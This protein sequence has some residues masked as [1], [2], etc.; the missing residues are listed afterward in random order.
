MLFDSGLLN[1]AARRAIVATASIRNAAQAGL[2]VANNARFQAAQIDLGNQS[3]DAMNFGSLTF[4]S[5]GSVLIAEDSDT[6]LVG[7]STA[8]SLAL[9]STGLLTNAG[10]ARLTVANLAGFSGGTVD[11]GNQI[12][13][14]LNCGTLSFNAAGA[15]TITENS[16]TVLAGSNAAGSLQ[17]TSGGAITDA[18]GTSLTVAGLAQLA[19]TGGAGITLDAANNFGSLTFH[20]TGTVR[21][22]ENSDMNLVGSNTASSLLLAPAANV[23]VESGAVLGGAGSVTGTLIVRPGGTV[24]PALAASGILGATQDLTLWPGATFVAQI[25]SAA[26]P[27]TINC[28]SAVP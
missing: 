16:D 13:D 11:L 27:D 19:D 2:T 20:S 4:N 7:T 21:I 15:V 5:A 3:I 17:L 8:G 12:S 6:L 18:T 23:F 28:N 26:P 1:V 22:T 14:A 10:M 25:N 24:S 9:S